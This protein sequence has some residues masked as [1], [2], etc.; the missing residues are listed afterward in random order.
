MTV[1]DWWSNPWTAEAVH[2]LIERL[3]ARRRSH[4]HGL[5]EVREI[6][7]E[8]EVTRLQPLLGR[9][10]NGGEVHGRRGRDLAHVENAG[11]VPGLSSTSLSMAWSCLTASWA[12]LRSCADVPLELLVPR[13][14]P[15]LPALCIRVPRPC[16]SALMSTVSLM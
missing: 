8:R 5:A 6:E 13:K 3:S 15:K 10:R 9:V 4:S 1:T 11:V 16:D 14:E 7:L 2:Q 12:A